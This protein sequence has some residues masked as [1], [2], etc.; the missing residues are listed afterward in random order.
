MPLAHELVDIDAIVVSSS[1]QTVTWSVWFYGEAVLRR[2]PERRFT[3]R[4]IIDHLELGY[5]WC[6]CIVCHDTQYV[7]EMAYHENMLCTNTV[8]HCSG[9]RDV[10][11]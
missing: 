7:T 1:P 11:R 4:D 6:S 5:T 10:R 2:H 3:V 8:H 9:R